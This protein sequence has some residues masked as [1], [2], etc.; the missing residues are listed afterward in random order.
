MLVTFMGLVSASILPT[1][2]LAIGSMSGTGRSVQKICDLHSDLRATTITLFRTL[3]RIG[4]VFA[5]LVVFSMTPDILFE[6]D[7]RGWTLEIPDVARRSAQ[8]LIFTGAVLVALEAYKIP[9]TFL[10]VLDIKRDI[11]I[12]EARRELDEMAPSE[13]DMKKIFPKKEDFGRT[14]G[15]DHLRK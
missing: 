5:A 11:A 2:S 8:V 6:I 14:F 7:L 13:S 9:Q 10:K 3:L 15:L 4:L 1:I 12:H